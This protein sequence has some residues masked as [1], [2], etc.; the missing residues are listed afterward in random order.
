M[1]NNLKPWDLLI[2]TLDSRV[3]ER[4]VLLATHLN[5]P[6]ATCKGK[7]PQFFVDE[8]LKRIRVQLLSPN[9]LLVPKQ[10]EV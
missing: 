8:A 1:D 10:V 2:T 5:L 7:K 6:K 4:T 9:I 3:L